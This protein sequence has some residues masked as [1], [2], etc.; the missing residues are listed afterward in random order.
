M[1]KLS[2]TEPNSRHKSKSSLI[3]RLINDVLA[4]THRHLTQYSVC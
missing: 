4:S 3:N 1:F 2:V